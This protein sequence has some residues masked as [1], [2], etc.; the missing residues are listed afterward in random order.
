MNE[1]GPLRLRR[2][3]A[4]APGSPLPAPQWQRPRLFAGLAAALLLPALAVSGCSFVGAAIR[5]S[6]ALQKAGFQGVS[7]NVTTGSGLPPDGVVRVSYTRGPTGN[8][9]QDG[10][11]A[12]RAVWNSFPYRF[13]ALA[14][15][16][17]SGG[18]AGPACVTQSTGVANATYAQLAARFGPRPAG[19][20]ATSAADPFSVPGWAIGLLVALLI[21]VVAVITTVVV[22]IV[23]RARPRAG[24]PGGWQP[25]PG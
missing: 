2:R 15:I 20:D 17:T 18:C 19:L 25:M 4:P 8:S 14:V 5:T 1:Q 6:S 10:Q 3:G 11:R 16:Q 12:E 13:G 22:V 9:G 7:L 24:P 21:V 23:R